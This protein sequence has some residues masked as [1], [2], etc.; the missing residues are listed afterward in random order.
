MIIENLTRPPSQCISIEFQ[1]PEFYAEAD[2]L[3]WIA[4]LM[5]HEYLH[6]DDLQQFKINDDDS[7]YLIY[8]KK[9]LELT[10]F[11]MEL[12]GVP[13]FNLPSIESIRYK[14]T[15]K[16]T[17]IAEVSADHA[18]RSYIHLFKTALSIASDSI[19]WTFGKPIDKQ[20]KAEIFNK[21]DHVIQKT[22]TPYTFSGQSTIPI[23][24]AVNNKNIPIVHLG[25]GVYQLG[26][27][28]EA[29]RMQRGSCHLDSAI[30]TRLAQNKAV[31][32]H[33]L[34]TAS[35]PSPSH[36]IVCK[37]EE[38]IPYVNQEDFPLVVK[39]I[40][41]DRGEGVTVD[42]YEIEELK[43]AIHK[44][45]ASSKTKQALVERQV[46]GMCHRFLIVAGK[47]V[48]AVMRGPIGV[49]GDG[50]HTIRALVDI[51]LEKQADLPVW[52]RTKIRPI[53]ELA[54][55]EIN[56]LGLSPDFIPNKNQ[57]VSLRR[58]E[59]TEWGGTTQDLTQTVHPD[60]VEIAIRAAQLF[61]LHIA[62]ID[63]ISP[64]ISQPWHRNGAI[65]NEVNSSPLIGRSDVSRFYLKD[66]LSLLIKGDGR[67]PIKIF[68]C[69]ALATD[70]YEDLMNDGKKAYLVD[71]HG[72]LDYCGKSWPSS[73]SLKSKVQALLTNPNV[74]ALVV[75]TQ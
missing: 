61:N 34:R 25:L 46:Q 51:E 7:N 12:G 53:D 2:M 15:P 16:N 58:I 63:I 19:R 9:I 38:A 31:T 70:A 36:T 13:V 24:R 30:G 32:A 18:Y 4:V 40:D 39:P 1:L 22:I 64:D 71:N 73:L 33:I 57:F 42:I 6:I 17:W 8:L 41:K 5:Q 11:I 21:I 48:Y 14:N 29:I 20:H 26:W 10:R 35:L 59:S 43:N 66:F 27:G 60:N 50:Q 69:Q 37:F 68:D 28:S 54:L 72:Y 56:R 67:I 23:L 55:I 52:A 65:I 44:A 3:N 62:G 74:D 45:C 75:V 49:F 47:L